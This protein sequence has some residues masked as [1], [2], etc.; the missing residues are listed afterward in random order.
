MNYKKASLPLML[1]LAASL[2]M[3]Q[4]S[5]GEAKKVS[6][7]ATGGTAP[8]EVVTSTST[9]KAKKKAAKKAVKKQV[10]KEEG[11]KPTEEKKAEQQP[12]TSTEVK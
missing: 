7:Q 8:K 11:Q 4:V 1:L 12:K 2:A 5:G 3:A 10:K 6:G 9:V